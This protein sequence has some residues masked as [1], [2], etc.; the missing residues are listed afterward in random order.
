MEVEQVAERL[1]EKITNKETGEVLLYRLKGQW[2]EV[3]DNRMRAAKKLGELEDAEEEGRLVVLPSNQ[4][5]ESE[6]DIVYYIYDYE[7]T[8]CVN[9]GISICADGKVWI[10]LAADEDIFPYREP[11]A[12]FDTDPTDWCKKTTD[13]LALEWGKTVFLT[14]EEAEKAL[15]EMEEKMHE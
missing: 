1:T 11:I 4:V 10:C 8:E 12:E 15:K 13:V 5:W 7:I 2:G 14:R 3:G 6:G 9:C